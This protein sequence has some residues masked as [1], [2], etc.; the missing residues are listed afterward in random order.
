M[1]IS[2]RPFVRKHSY[3][4]TR[5]H[6]CHAFS[7]Q[8]QTLGSILQGGARGQHKGYLFYFIESFVFEQ[9][10]L[11]HLIFSVT[12]DLRVHDKGLG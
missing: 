5:Y 8:L 12:S 4:G 2:Y 7:R 9:Q 6:S 3:L 11:F 10:V 1:Q